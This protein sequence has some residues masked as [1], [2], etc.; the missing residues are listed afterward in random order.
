MSKT[1]RLAAIGFAML[2]IIMTALL[3]LDL[4]P[5]SWTGLFMHLLPSLV[6]LLILLISLTKA[7]IG[8]ILWRLAAIAYIVI[9]WGDVEWLAYL[10]MSGPAFIIGILFLWPKD[11]GIYVPEATPQTS[12]IPQAAPPQVESQEDQA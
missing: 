5:F 8:G 7:K 2:F 12:A 3:A 6:L 11:S 10:V 1:I 4:N 9:A